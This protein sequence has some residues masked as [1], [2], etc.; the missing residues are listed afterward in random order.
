MWRRL[1]RVRIYNA[2]GLQLVSGPN[3]L[4]GAPTPEHYQRRLDNDFHVKSERP[5][6]DVLDVKINHLVK[7]ELASAT[8]LP[9]ACHSRRGRQTLHM[10]LGVVRNLPR[11][12]RPWP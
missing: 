3:L 12:R 10:R 2:R 8:D 7:A 9:Q 11:E 1:H 6:A 4:P 5:I